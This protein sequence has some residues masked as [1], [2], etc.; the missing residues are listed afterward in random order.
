MCLPTNPSMCVYVYVHVCIYA[1]VNVRACGV[2]KFSFER[3]LC[4][5][6]C[7]CVCDI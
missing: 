6:L 3:A 5:F 2:G 4:T 7:V 1:S